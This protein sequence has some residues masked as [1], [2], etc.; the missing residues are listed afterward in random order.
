[1]KM[2]QTRPVEDG[3]DRPVED[4]ADQAC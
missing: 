3:A 1:L 2:V 4:G